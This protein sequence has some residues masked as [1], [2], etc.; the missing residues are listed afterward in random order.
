MTLAVLFDL[1]GVISDTASL[2]AKAWK[3]VFDKVLANA[4]H[5]FVPFDE[6]V[7]Y[8]RHV[9]GKS[10]LVG[11]E[12]FLRSRGIELHQGTADAA[13]IETIHGIGNSKNTIFRELLESDGV[14]IFED[15]L[16]AINTLRNCGAEIGLASSS[17]NAR[18]VLEKAGLTECFKSIF[19]GM[20][21]ENEGVASKPDPAFYR[22]AAA[23]LGQ[24][25]NQCIVLEDAISGVVSAKLAG[26]GLVIGLCRNGNGDALVANGANFTVSSLDELELGRSLDCFNSPEL[27][28]KKIRNN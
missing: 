24:N 9:D 20:V 26:A 5:D 17:K 1:D 28:L 23:L 15:A 25:P 22:H 11:I 19:D 4:R 6:S 10:R 21:A 13:G 12:D 18:I 3:V 14:T 7:D 16:R 27:L 8:L 2:H